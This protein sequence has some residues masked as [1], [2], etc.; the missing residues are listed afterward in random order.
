VEE[1]RHKGSLTPQKARLNQEISTFVFL[2]VMKTLCEKKGVGRKAIGVG[3]CL[4]G[5]VLK[6][7]INCAQQGCQI[8][9]GA[10]YQSAKNVPKLPKIYQVAMKHTK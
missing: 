9:L 6:V 5:L 2:L 8:F 7:E 3:H 1:E 4:S 10:T